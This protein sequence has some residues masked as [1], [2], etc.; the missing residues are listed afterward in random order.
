MAGGDDFVDESRPVVRPFLLEDRDED[1][2]Q[3][4]QQD[5]LT[6]QALFGVGRLD[7]KFNNKVADTCLYQFRFRGAERWI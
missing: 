4:V 3:L 7:D 1:K 5:A 6:S 2:V